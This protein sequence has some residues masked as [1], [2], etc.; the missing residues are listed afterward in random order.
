MDLGERGGWQQEMGG[1]EERETVVDMYCVGDE[2]MS[3]K[4]F[5]KSF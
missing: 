2:T 1:L 4:T 3:N 5:L